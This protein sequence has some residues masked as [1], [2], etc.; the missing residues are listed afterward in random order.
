MTRGLLAVAS[1]VPV[2]L[3]QGLKIWVVRSLA[4]G[5]TWPVWGEIF[6]LTRVHNSGAAFGLFPQGTSAFLA[7]S[8]AVVLGLG[9]YLLFGRPTGLRALGAAFIWGGAV[10]NLLDRARLGYVVDLLSVGHFPVFNVADA[11]LVL[12]VTLFAL[13]ILRGP[14]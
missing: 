8:A 4:P 14:R 11:A 10:G 3:D 5:E 9:L 12:G 6:R 1:L 13:G 2:I 7:A